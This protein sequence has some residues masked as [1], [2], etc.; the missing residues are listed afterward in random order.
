MPKPRIESD[1]FV[2]SYIEPIAN[3]IIE[4]FYTQPVDE[5]AEQALMYKFGEAGSELEEGNFKSISVTKK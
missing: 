1:K 3:N 4:V 5:D 2:I